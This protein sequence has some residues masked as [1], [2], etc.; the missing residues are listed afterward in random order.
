M[1]IL[2]PMELYR[3]C[4]LHKSLLSPVQMHNFSVRGHFTEGRDQHVMR[5]VETTVLS[6]PDDLFYVK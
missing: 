4:F 3:V 5:V 1:Y 6:F 2:I